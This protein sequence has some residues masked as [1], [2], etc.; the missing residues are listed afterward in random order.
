LKFDSQDR[1]EPGS[2]AY[3]A[4]AVVPTYEN[5][6]T[7][8]CVAEKLV[9]LGLPVIIVD[10]GSGPAARAELERLA[11]FP[12][13][14][15]FYR[16][17]NG[18]KGAAVQD[19]FQQALT[20]G[21]THALQ[22]DA[23]GQHDLSDVPSFIEVSKLNPEA[24]V[25]G[26]PIFDESAPRGRLVGRKI[27][28]FWCA[29][30]TLGLKIHDPLCGFRIYPLKA[31]ARLGRLGARMEFDSDIGV[32]LVWAKVPVINLKTKVLYLAKV[33]GG[34][35]HFRMFHDNVRI[36]LL[37][38]RLVLTGLLLLLTWPL[39][40]TWSTIIRESHWDFR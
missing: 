15:R 21:F 13:I 35:S 32:R 1:H 31:C 33:D 4:C 40:R 34:V 2:L 23:D 7:I 14:H 17:I 29:V 3:R 36:S 5:P 28:V 9:A 20:L 19:G 8:G 37:H 26:S 22:V 10:D 12:Q 11:R 6:M 27:S 24:L 39:R 30:E 38:T 18:G 16:E 25:C